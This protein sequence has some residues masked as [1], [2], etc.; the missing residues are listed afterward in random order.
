MR[1]VA[2]EA[3]QHG[4]LDHSDVRGHSGDRRNGGA[5]AAAGVPEVA[6]I[7]CGQDRAVGLRPARRERHR[8]TRGPATATQSAL[9]APAELPRAA[10][11]EADRSRRRR[12]RAGPVVAD[13]RRAPRR[14]SGRDR[15]RRAADEGRGGR[16]GHP[17]TD[18]RTGDAVRVVAGIAGGDHMRSRSHGAGRVGH[19]ATCRSAAAR[20][21]AGA[22][23]AE[24]AATVA[25]KPHRSGGRRRAA[26]QIRDR[27]GA[28]CRSTGEHGAGRAQD[29]CC[30]GSPGDGD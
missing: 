8:T 13:G 25:R 20:Q 29:R 3:D 11:R 23:V 22:S 10:A 4:A 6:A 24:A 28:C 9:T 16:A 30:R 19:V 7:A 17:Q 21:H 2:R 18:R 27:R 5:A 15:G 26:P 14:V 1:R 12:R